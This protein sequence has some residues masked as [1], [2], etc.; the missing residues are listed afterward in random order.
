[1]YEKKYTVFITERDFGGITSKPC[2]TINSALELTDITFNDLRIPVDNMIGRL[3]HGDE[4][5]NQIYPEYR[6]GLGL[7]NLALS[8]SLIN[9]VTDHL[10]RTSTELQPI[11]DTDSVLSK[12]A[13]V[14]YY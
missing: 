2:D 13:E 8:K 9:N 10:I 6:L 5:L 11:Y 1:M 4:I 12:I 14:L 3:N 7:I